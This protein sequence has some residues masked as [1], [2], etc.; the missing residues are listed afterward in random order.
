MSII[1]DGKKVAR[2]IRNELKKEIHTATL[3]G[4]VPPALAII[5]IGNDPASDLYIKNKMK[6]CEE[7]G[8]VAHHHRLAID[9]PKR[10]GDKSYQLVNEVINSYNNLSDIH[11]IILQL[12]LPPG[13]DSSNILWRIDQM[14]DVDGLSPESLGR[15]L[16]GDSP[17]G[18]GFQPCTPRGI[19]R[20]LQE[21]QISVSGVNVVIVGRSNLVGKPLAMMMLKEDATVTICHRKSRDLRKIVHAAD[22]VVF[23]TG[24]PHH[25]DGS[26]I[27]NGAIVIDVG[28]SRWFDGRFVGDYNPQQPLP[29]QFHNE[30]EM[31]IPYCYT[32]VPGGV[33]P[34]TRAMLLDNILRA[35]KVQTMTADIITNMGLD[36][37][38]AVA[39]GG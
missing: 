16:S 19:M 17:S 32:P 13:W 26:W 15:V 33:G 27:K 11:G 37:G 1:L 18:F 4:G 21:Y 25:F 23:A 22:I 39:T 10:V 9:A 8:I 24:S 7:V 28:I 12:P 6:D 29:G 36:W 30:L 34:M 35:Y 5:Q 38:E 2:E 31:G 14:K 20:L 3:K